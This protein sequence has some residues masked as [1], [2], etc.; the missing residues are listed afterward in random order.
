MTQLDFAFN[1]VGIHGGLFIDYKIG[2]ERAPM[3]GSAAY[4]S[5]VARNLLIKYF[6]ETQRPLRST[7]LVGHEAAFG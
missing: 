6:H 1:A 2:S 5:Q 4:R 7:R 3:R